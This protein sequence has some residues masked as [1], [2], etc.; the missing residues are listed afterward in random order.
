VNQVPDWREKYRSAIE[1]LDAETK[2]WKRLEDVLRR[3]VRRLCA[4]AQGIDARLDEELGVV[5]SAIRTAENAEAVDQLLARVTTAVAAFDASRASTGQHRESSVG[6]A[7]APAAPPT[8]VRPAAMEPAKVLPAATPPAAAPSNEDAATDVPAGLDGI[9][10]PLLLIL[11]RLGLIATDKSEVARV[12]SDLSEPVS[13][14]AF[15]QAVWRLGDLVAAERRRLEAEKA[16]SERVLK[17]VSSRLGEIASFLAASQADQGEADRSG[18]ELNDRLRGEVQEIGSTVQ[19][20][21]DLG[22]LQLSVKSRLEAID[23]HL[24]A[25]RAREERRSHAYR[26]RAERMGE[27][28]QQLENE[29]V[30][31]ERSLLREQRMALLDALTGI[32][33]RLGYDERIVQEFKRWRRF[34]QPL[35][36]VAWDLDRFK[37]VNDSYGHRA[38]DRVLRAFAKLLSEKVRETDFVARYGG[39]EFIM[40]L[41]GTPA[42]GARTVAEAIREDIG[43][44]GFHFRG[45]PVTVTASCGVTDARDG[46]TP[47]SLFD[48]ADRALYQAKESGRNRSIVD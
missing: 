1:Q 12:R 46:D 7:G 32:A 9:S 47:E 31:L 20:A 22:E 21:T 25:F 4:A 37:N 44:L 34:R 30:A 29:T 36:L 35:S 19:I 14:A 2:R 48:R 15:E 45:T 28:I 41:I 10:E 17:Q 18:R 13:L 43:R 16:E 24:Q 8:A 39:E 23:T 27:R 11:D 5:A 6:P 33:N 38:G 42:E 26:E 3:L 40:L